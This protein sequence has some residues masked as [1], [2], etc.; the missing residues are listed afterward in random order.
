MPADRLSY[1]IISRP[2]H[3]G[4]HRLSTKKDYLTV[5]SSNDIIQK[6][7]TPITITLPHV[8]A[9]VADLSRRQRFVAYYADLRSEPL[10]CKVVY[11]I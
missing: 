1:N 11:G 9:A 5:L 3:Q 2:Y 4:Y 10:V 8:H 6:A 7:A